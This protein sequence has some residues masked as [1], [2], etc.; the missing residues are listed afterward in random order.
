LGDPAKL[1]EQIRQLAESLPLEASS[2]LADV[3]DRSVPGEWGRLRAEAQ[4]V[5]PQPAQRERVRHLL[6]GWEKQYPELTPQAVSLALKTAAYCIAQAH[7]NQELELVWTGPHGDGTALRRTDQVL[8]QLIND[9]TARLTIVSFAVYKIARIG[10]SLVQAANR[11]VSLR[12]IV[13]SPRES[14]GKIDYDGIAALGKQVTSHAQLYLWPLDQRPHSEGGKHGSL[15]VKCAVAD[16]R[17][18][19]ISSANLTE[20]AMTMN[21]E[22]GVFVRG[23]LLPTQV[24][25]HFEGLIQKG[26]LVPLK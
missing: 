17:D 8:L 5:V 6:D 16:G 21:M 22:M 9:A 11:G 18:L 2:A 19:L 24:E 23:G 7:R 15:H 14:E 1:V 20:Y 13:E 25:Q 4:A 3:I 12:I 10:E 26:I